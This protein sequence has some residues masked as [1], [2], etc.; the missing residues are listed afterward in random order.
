M[1]FRVPAPLALAALLLPAC[2][3]GHDDPVSDASL[4]DAMPRET[5]QEMKLLLAGELGEATLHGGAGDL[6]RIRLTAPVAKLDWNLHGHAGGSTQ[7]VLEELGIAT[8]DYTFAPEAT[9]DWSLLL[10]NKDSAPFTVEVHVE[11]YGAMT[12]SG[13]E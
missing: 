11:L 2:G 12:W 6:A 5:I 3:P 9:A 1:N 4:A 10:R 13:W 7:T 8:A